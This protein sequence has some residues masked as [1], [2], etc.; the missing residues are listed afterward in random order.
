MV[1]IHPRDFARLKA[2]GKSVGDMSLVSRTLSQARNV[3]RMFGKDVRGIMRANRL[4]SGKARSYVPGQTRADVL[5]G[6]EATVAAITNQTHQKKKAHAL[7]TIQGANPAPVKG[8]N[9]ADQRRL[10]AAQ[11]G[12]QD[13]GTRKAQ[14]KDNQYAMAKRGALIGGT[15][16]LGTAV[17]LQGIKTYKKWRKKAKEQTQHRGYDV[18]PEHGH[19]AVGQQVYNQ[20]YYNEAREELINLIVE[21]FRQQ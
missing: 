8:L 12:L 4:R 13:I 1:N 14:W 21:S 3:G 17:G 2:S 15:A 5:A 6:L 20:P 18:Y 9:I 11:K 19:A 16:I 7:A 10:A